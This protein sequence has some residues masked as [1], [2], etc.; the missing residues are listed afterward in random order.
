MNANDA[1]VRQILWRSRELDNGFYAIGIEI[2]PY[3]LVG[4]LVE[5]DGMVTARARRHLAVMDPDEVVKRVTEL[6][7][8][9]VT[10]ALGCGF[11][12]NRVC[13]GVQV[14]GPVDPDTGTVL[15]LI[16]GRDDHGRNKPP[17][18]EWVNVPLGA[19][20]TA[21]SGC[22]TAVE[23]DAHAFA[24]YEQ[25][26]GVGQE[27]ATFAVILIRDGVGAGLVV[28]RER[29][30]APTEF[31]HLLVWPR[32]RIC[33]CGM[34]GCIESQVGSRALTAVV[35]ERTGRELDGLEA[36]IA[37]ADS[38]ATQAPQAVAAF[39]KAGT[40]IARGIATVLTVFGPSHVI[41]YATEGLITGG[42]GHRAANTFLR[43]VH[44]F[45]AHTLHTS[46]GC[47]LR[48]Q[49]LDAVRGAHGA[50]LI[51]LQSCFG[52]RLQPH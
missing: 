33:D 45:P 2:L 26:L 34:R 31:G 50:A 4:V 10:D 27:S 1:K 13:L 6:A 5:T 20:L 25:K 11:P 14:G 38:N 46:R 19:R 24:A 52:I 41:V 21:A 15:H 40:S 23:N 43:A 18:Y 9:L 29:L 12:R 35:K 28:R 8:K 37:L 30:H 47:Q 36:A 42:P 44:T 3:E 39:R 17:P 32:G 48:T 7:G 16:N 51:A 22:A 49:R